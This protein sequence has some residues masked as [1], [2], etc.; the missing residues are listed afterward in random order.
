LT[1]NL[2]ILSVQ[3][4]IRGSR[5]IFQQSQSF[6]S[7]ETNQKK[8][9]DPFHETD[10]S[11]WPPWTSVMRASTRANE[12]DTVLDPNNNKEK[13]NTAELRRVQQLHGGSKYMARFLYVY[14]RKGT[15]VIKTWGS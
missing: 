12:D 2:V 8:G 11:E 7:D 10:R 15:G 9:F 14:S 13:N 1:I 4:L 5:R 6:Q 3:E